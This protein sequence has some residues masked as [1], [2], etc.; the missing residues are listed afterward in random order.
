MMKLTD[1]ISRLQG[2]SD[3]HAIR[4]ATESNNLIS[5]HVSSFVL[6]VK[7]MEEPNYGSTL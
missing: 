3:L 1:V 5:E 2:A 7:T 6:E 4:T